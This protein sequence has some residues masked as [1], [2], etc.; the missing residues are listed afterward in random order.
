[1]NNPT[2]N[3]LITEDEAIELTMNSNN[4]TAG[5]DAIE[6]IA[7]NLECKDKKEVDRL[8]GL[9][10]GMKA[11]STENSNFLENLVMKF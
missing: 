5:L 9:I 3:R 8:A 6:T 1:M 7:L 10:A 2:K 4:L 11:L